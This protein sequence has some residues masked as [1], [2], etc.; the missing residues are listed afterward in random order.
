MSKPKPTRIQAKIKKGEPAFPVKD[1]RSYH[2]VGKDSV[3]IQA[4]IDRCNDLED[5]RAIR[6]V[7]AK[8][9]NLALAMKAAIKIDKLR[10]LY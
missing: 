7:L 2:M 3:E 6:N 5:A 1:A 4:E 8:G 10:G 9:D